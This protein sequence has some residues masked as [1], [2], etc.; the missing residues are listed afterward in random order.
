MEEIYTILYT[1]FNAAKVIDE[2]EVIN[3]QV[4]NETFVARKF[5]SS[6]VLNVVQA[7]ARSMPE[8]RETLS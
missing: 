5:L 3:D 1:R 8:T 2:G 4:S 6:L 7:N